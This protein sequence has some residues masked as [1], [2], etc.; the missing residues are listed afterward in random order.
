MRSDDLLAAYPR[1]PRPSRA[2]AGDHD[3]DLKPPSATC[4][5]AAR[6]PASKF[7]ISSFSSC[8]L[9]GR[10]G[11]GGGVLACGVCAMF[12]ARLLP[13]MPDRG[14]YSFRSDDA[15]C[16]LADAAPD[17]TEPPLARLCSALANARGGSCGSWSANGLLTGDVGCRLG[18]CSLR[19]SNL[20]TVGEQM[21]EVGNTIGLP[22]PPPSSQ[23]TCLRDAG[24]WVLL[25]PSPSAGPRGVSG[26]DSARLKMDCRY[27]R[28]RS[29]GGGD[30]G[31]M[32]ARGLVDRPLV[33][34]LL[35]LLLPPPPLTFA[36]DM[37]YF[38]VAADVLRP[39]WCWLCRRCACSRLPWKESVFLLL[40]RLHR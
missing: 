16:A 34:L 32:S 23:K 20:L 33:T 27:L 1:I 4:G 22:G 2:A 18:V 26:G 21:G 12:V 36:F 28:S 15:A 24:V 17:P 37:R 6:G 29:R 40:F 5:E 11:L 19:G 39:A 35:L 30:S 38:A 13:L 8:G 14:T 25:S 7:G 9:G 10:A 3:G 31:T